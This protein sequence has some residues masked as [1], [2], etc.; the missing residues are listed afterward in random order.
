MSDALTESCCTYVLPGYCHKRKSSHT[1]HAR[2]SPAGGG[3][4][5]KKKAEADA[6]E[7]E[8]DGGVWGPYDNESWE[9]LEDSITPHTHMMEPPAELLMPLLPYQ[10]QFLSWAVQQVGRR[11]GALGSGLIVSCVCVNGLQYICLRDQAS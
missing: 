8:D 11:A 10:K 2:L 5:R 6:D 3:R 1:V 7:D 4:G 9:A